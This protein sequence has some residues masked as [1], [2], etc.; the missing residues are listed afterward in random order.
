MSIAAPVVPRELH[1]WLRREVDR[2]CTHEAIIHELMMRGID[3]GTT[4]QLI[5]QHL[6]QVGPVRQVSPVSLP[7]VTHLRKGGS[8]N[9]DG[10]F[11]RVRQVWN[12]ML[13]A[14]LDNVLTSDECEELIR[15]SRSRMKQSRIVDHDTGEDALHPE[16]VS[17]GAFYERCADAFIASIET[18]LAKIM[19]RPRQN[20]EGL[21]ILR[22]GVGGEYRPHY[23]YFDPALPGSQRHLARGGQ[24]VATLIMYLNEPEDGGA[25]AFPELGIKVVPRRGSAV[26]FE[27][28]DSSGAID[29]RSLHAGEPVRKGEKWIATKWVRQHVHH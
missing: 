12:D 15:R 20:G 17:E 9:I 24:R 29:S 25:T 10:H 6:K 27:Y 28:A 8:L 21:Q 7:R 19:D 4:R 22:Y 3:P 11:V 14:V 23:D 5:L 18:R 16:R 1:D 26:Y 13:V 2:G